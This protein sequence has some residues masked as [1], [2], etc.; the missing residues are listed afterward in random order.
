MEFLLQGGDDFV[1][2]FGEAFNPETQKSYEKIAAIN[3]K[4]IG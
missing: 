4:R 2:V 3:V 1:R